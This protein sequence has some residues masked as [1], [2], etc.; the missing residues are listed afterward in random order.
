M[1]EVV[2]IL[3]SCLVVRDRELLLQELLL[4]MHER[5]NVTLIIVTHDLNVANLAERQIEV[6]DG[7]VIDLKNS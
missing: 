2:F 7:K 6:L 4:I 3:L 5:E 1:I